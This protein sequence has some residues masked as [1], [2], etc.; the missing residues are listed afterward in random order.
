VVNSS[1]DNLDDIIRILD[2]ESE[3]V[4]IGGPGEIRNAVLSNFNLLRLKMF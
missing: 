4:D 3:G 2:L 1:E